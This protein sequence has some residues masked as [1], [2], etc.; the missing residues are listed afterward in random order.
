MKGDTTNMT[1]DWN[2]PVQV[3]VGFIDKPKAVWLNALVVIP[4]Q[5]GSHNYAMVVWDVDGQQR[6][7]LFEANN[8]DIRNA[9][10]PP[11][12]E[13]VWVGILEHK[14]GSLSA[15]SSYPF[16]FAVQQAAEYKHSQRLIAV[17][18]VYEREVQQDG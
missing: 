4:L 13:Q 5:V 1:V 8:A 10:E 11:K 9:P 15:T 16:V 3:R 6:H 18:L 7:H 2:K 12:K 17:K 14:D